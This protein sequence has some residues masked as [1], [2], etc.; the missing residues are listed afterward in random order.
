MS[1]IR[2]GF[3]RFSAAAITIVVLAGAGVA[4]ASAGIG[5]LARPRHEASRQA[6]FGSTA[7]AYLPTLQWTLI[8][9]ESAVAS[10]NE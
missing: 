9:I 1:T 4:P 3:S 2:K 10:L 7:F 6:S 5:G 8:A